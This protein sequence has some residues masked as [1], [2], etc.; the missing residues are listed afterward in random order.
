MSKFQ[1][2]EKIICLDI[3]AKADISDHEKKKETEKKLEHKLGYK[4]GRA[5]P[6]LQ[7]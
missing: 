4:Q 5:K 3:H 2:R 1:N 7:L 6:G